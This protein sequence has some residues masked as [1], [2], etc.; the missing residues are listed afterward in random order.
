ME[1]DLDDLFDRLARSAFRRRFRLGVVESGYLE[2]KGLEAVMSHDETFI[3][4]RLA[5]ADIPND[6]K[7]TPM[8]NHPIFIAQHGTATCCRDCLEKWHRIPKGHALTA[9]EKAYIL[10]V[11]CRWLDAQGGA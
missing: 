10:S 2:R 9:E 11:L 8:R 5:P 4:E 3:E 6:G 1:P 7:Q